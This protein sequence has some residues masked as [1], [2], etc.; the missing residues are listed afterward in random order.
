[1]RK[2]SPLS[3][4]PVMAGEVDAGLTITT[5]F[6]IATLLAEAMLE[7]EQSAPTMAATPSEFTRRSADAVAAAASTH[8][9]SATTASSLIPPGYPDSNLLESL[10]SWRRS[11][12]FS[13]KYQYLKY[14]EN[15][16]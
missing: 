8:V 6:G 9:V 13:T 2:K 15:Q 10:T 7:P 11:F 12:H 5:P 3:S 14:D 1:M 16:L 4:S